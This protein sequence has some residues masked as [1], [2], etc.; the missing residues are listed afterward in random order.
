LAPLVSVVI[1]SFNHAR[2]VGQAMGSVLEQTHDE[3]ELIVVDDGSTDESR[4][5]L[6][7]FR[8]PRVR[9]ELQENAGAHAAINR[10]LGLARGELIAILN[11]DDRFAPDRLAR[12]AAAFETDPRLGLWGSYIEV[13]DRR[14]TPTGIKEGFHNL[15]PVPLDQ[16]A[17]SFQAEPD[18]RL[19]LLLSNYWSTT[20]NFVFRRALLDDVGG[21]ERLRFAHDWD[22]AFRAQRAWP[23]LLEPAPLLQYRLHGANTIHQ[24]RVE[25]V[26]EIL[27][28]L[29][30]HLPDYLDHPGLDLSGGEGT[31]RRLEQLRHSLQPHGCWRTFSCMCTLLHAAAARHE[32]LAEKLLEPSNPVRRWLLSQIAE[33]LPPADSAGSPLSLGRMRSRL[34]R[35]LWNDQPCR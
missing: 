28:V 18:L 19:N 15:L 20:S 4:D 6:R 34:R 27:W 22:F 30:R 11:S 1:P 13:I 21:M 32:P 2:F 14:G 16:P 35:M 10:G 26:F 3:L 33:E 25:M 17:R 12:A 29:A 31:L 8:D 24:N 23:A 9:I 7:T 5:V